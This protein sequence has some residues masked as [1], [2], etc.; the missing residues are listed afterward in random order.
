MDMYYNLL[1][2]YG[3]L[4]QD[5]PKDFII[6][7]DNSKRKS[8]KT[9][10]ENIWYLKFVDEY[11]SVFYRD[12]MLES[13]S[14]QFALSKKEYSNHFFKYIMDFLTSNKSFFH[15]II[16]GV[17]I[18]DYHGEILNITTLI[19]G[20]AII[21]KIMV[22]NIKKFFKNLRGITLKDCIIAE[23]ALLSDLD[24]DLNLI[25]CEIKNINSFGYCVQE[26]RLSRCQIDKI[27]DTTINSSKISII[28]NTCED[29]NLAY[30]F[31]KCHF[32]EL[33]E[34]EIGRNSKAEDGGTYFNQCLN[35]IPYAC[36]MLISLIIDGKI[37]SFD[38]LH[39]FNQLSYCEIRSVNDT[40]GVYPIINP[41]IVNDKERNEIISKS[42]REIKTDMD[43]HL[44]MY[45]KQQE[46]LASLSMINY[47]DEEKRFYL[48]EAPLSILLNPLRYFKDEEIKYYYTFD[49]KN[50]NLILHSDHSGETHIINNRFYVIR[51]LLEIYVIKQK[52]QFIPSVPFVYHPTGIPIIFKND[53]YSREDYVNKALSMEEWYTIDADDYSLTKHNFDKMQ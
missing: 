13:N 24:C 6:L 44:A 45:D 35:F 47:T 2:Y 36:P 42:S 10:N 51:E 38:F 28:G 46:I 48:G 5:E 31:L 29:E 34:L 20:N 43:M 4:I 22:R 49:S 23:D 11:A 15:K 7:I 53:G 27:A 33:E 3:R 12:E 19:L 30:L 39:H 9:I 40:I 26:L 25:G 17:L 1:D 41:Y 37:Y 52:Q 18:N 16:N 21:D 32:P 8:F 14:L 50:N